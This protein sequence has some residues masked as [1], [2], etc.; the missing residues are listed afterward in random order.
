MSGGWGIGNGEWGMGGTVG[1][2]AGVIAAPLISTGLQS[3][4]GANFTP[5]GRL[6]RSNGVATESSPRREPWVSRAE[7]ASRRAAAERPRGPS[8]GPSFLPPLR[9][10]RTSSTTPTAHAVGYYLS[11]LRCCNQRSRCGVGV[12]TQSAEP[13][14][15]ESLHSRQPHP[16]TSLLSSLSPIPHPRFPPQ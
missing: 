15:N 11:Q 8:N 2:G 13:G 14:A 7:A 3:G 5:F 6:R 16:A 12:L 9:G 1:R 4:G 10:L